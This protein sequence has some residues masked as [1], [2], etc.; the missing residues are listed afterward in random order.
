MGN[1]NYDKFDILLGGNTHGDLQSN[2]LNIN[3]AFNKKDNEFN[4]FD[5]LFK[6]KSNLFDISV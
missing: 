6:T 2:E 5:A 1:I 3:Q 4:I